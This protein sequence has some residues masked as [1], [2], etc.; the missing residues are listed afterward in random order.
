MLVKMLLK[1]VLKMVLDL[2]PRYLG[3]LGR[4]HGTKMGF[5]LD[6]HVPENSNIW[7]RSLDRKFGRVDRRWTGN[8]YSIFFGKKFPVHLRSI[9]G[10]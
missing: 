1:M 10:P 5:S 3:G 8:F 7:T 4:D 9:S 2:V 6:H